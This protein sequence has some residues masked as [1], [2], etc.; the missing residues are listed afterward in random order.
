MT[1]YPGI[2]VEGQSK[3]T[4]TYT[5]LVGVPAH[6]EPNKRPK[7]YRQN[8]LSRWHKMY[9][10]HWVV[11]ILSST[12]FVKEFQNIYRVTKSLYAPEDYN[13]EYYLA[14]SDCLAADH[15][16]QGNTRLT[17]TPSVIPNSNY[18][19]MVSDWNCLKYFCVFLYCNHQVYRDFLITLYYR[20]HENFLWRLPSTI[21][22]V[23]KLLATCARLVKH[24][25][26]HSSLC[27]GIKNEFNFTSNFSICNAGMV[28]G[29]NDYVSILQ[30]HF[31]T[32]TCP[33]G[34]V[35]DTE[36]L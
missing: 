13:T 36:W 20:L 10:C 33:P 9:C 31:Q 35:L 18:A 25:D 30:I 6:N 26:G 21:Q 24:E 14:Q 1:Q 4:K 7:Y 23:Q 12:R 28:Q 27:S 34:E 17:P 8:D 19:I 22:W 16:G 5:C 15:Q 11:T 29:H 3:T 2:H 32:Q